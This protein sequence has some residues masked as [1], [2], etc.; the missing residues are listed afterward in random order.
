[1][2]ILK[3][4]ELHYIRLNPKYLSDTFNKDNP[5]YEVQIR[6]TS[7]E[8]MKEWKEEFS[9]PVRTI[10]P[11]NEEEGFYFCSNIKKN[12]FKK[13]GTLSIPVE[14]VDGNLLPLDPNLIASG[15]VGNVM[16]LQR[17]YV[18]TN[19]TPAKVSILMKVQ[20]TKLIKRKPSEFK[21]DDFHEEA[22]EVIELQEEHNDTLTEGT[23]SD[24]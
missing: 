6:T 11:E 5:T 17:D 18:K 3:N 12:K 19:G 22:M 1:M 8:V 2:P 15:S 20:I 10:I 9:L 14:V 21:R 16:I 24:Y 7:K 4:C 13:D 23:D